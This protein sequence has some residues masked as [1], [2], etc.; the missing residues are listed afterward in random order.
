MSPVPSLVESATLSLDSW[1]RLRHVGSS[2]ARFIFIWVPYG[3]HEAGN[4][5]VLGGWHWFWPLVFRIA[6]RPGDDEMA[7]SGLLGL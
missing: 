2:L 4:S 5:Q 3:P 1:P 7:S 6:W